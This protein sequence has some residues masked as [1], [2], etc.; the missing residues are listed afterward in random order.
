MSLRSQIEAKY[1]IVIAGEEVT[2]GWKDIFKK[3]AALLL[4]GLIFSQTALGL[5]F[6]EDKLHTLEKQMKHTMSTYSHESG[7]N[8]DFKIDHKKVGGLQKVQFKVIKDGKV[9]G[10]VDFIGSESNTFDHYDAGMTQDG[11]NDVWVSM[12]METTIEGL[13]KILTKDMGK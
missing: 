4:G 13:N 2:A 11:R 3:S 10:Q 8:Y 12:V 5:T 1:T 9:A 7:G 6:K